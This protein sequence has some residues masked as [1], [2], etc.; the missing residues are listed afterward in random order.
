MAS[1]RSLRS[2]RLVAATRVRADVRDAP[3]VRELEDMRDVA[4]ARARFRTGD[5]VHFEIS[6]LDGRGRAVTDMALT[7]SIFGLDSAGAQFFDDGAFVA[8]NPGSYRVIVTAGGS[9]ALATVE[10]EARPPATEVEL[11]GRGLTP[12]VSTSDLWIFEGNDGRDYAYT[13]THADGGGQR[14]Y[15]WDV[16]VASDI[17]LRD[18]V[19][20]DARV[21]TMLK[22][23]ATRAGLS[24]RGKGPAPEETA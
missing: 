16:T 12:D 18:S 20:V 15:V 10:V 14:M 2:T 6:A 23:T 3:D 7:Y 5:V 4:E 22:S 24:S 19:V 1:A 11:V 13:G 9:A 17:Q 21:V 8:E